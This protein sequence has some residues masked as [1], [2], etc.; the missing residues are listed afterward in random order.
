MGLDIL[1][2]ALDVWSEEDRLSMNHSVQ[3]DINCLKENVLLTAH[4]FIHISLG[5]YDGFVYLL[6]KQVTITQQPT[7]FRRKLTLLKI[8]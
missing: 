1:I 6:P 3:E 5:Q 2:K 7:I 8:L 4:A